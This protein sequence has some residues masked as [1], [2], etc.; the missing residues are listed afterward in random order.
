[1]MAYSLQ[2]F[3]NAQDVI[4]GLC[5]YLIA[6]VEDPGVICESCMVRL[7][8]RLLWAH[9][10]GDSKNYAYAVDVI[11]RRGRNAVCESMGPR[12]GWVAMTDFVERPEAYLL[13]Y[14]PVEDRDDGFA[15][16]YFTK[17]E[18]ER[19]NQWLDE[20][21]DSLGYDE[22]EDEFFTTADPSIEERF[23][24]VD[25]DGNHLYPIGTYTWLW[26]RI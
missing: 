19:M 11:Q 10:R 20:Y 16:P 15:A 13:A 5:A 25:I 2:D 18:V 3:R 1:M 17:Q 8:D 21:G 22:G 12:W 6:G 9:E 7:T 26:E 23:R 24:G 4:C 14:I